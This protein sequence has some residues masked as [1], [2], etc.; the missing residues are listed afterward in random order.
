MR[1]ELI[2]T[3]RT[4]HLQVEDVR[5][6]TLGQHGDVLAGAR[7]GAADEPRRHLVPVQAA[8][9]VVLKRVEGAPLCRRA[10][11]RGR[12]ASVREGVAGGVAP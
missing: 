2:L 6:T 12:G 5:Y 10:G 11:R 3:A 9:G 8:L 4:Q 1:A 7:L